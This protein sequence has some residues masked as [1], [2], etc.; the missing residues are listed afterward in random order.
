MSLALPSARFPLPSAKVYRVLCAE[1]GALCG[2]KGV[3]FFLDSRLYRSPRSRP[4]SR[5]YAVS[6]TLVYPSSP[7]PTL[8]VRQVWL[9]IRVC[10][11][12]YFI[13]DVVDDARF[14]AFL[15]QRCTLR[16]FDD[17]AIQCPSPP[18]YPPP[19][20]SLIANLLC[21]DMNAHTQTLSYVLI[22]CY[23][24]SS[25]YPFL[26][27]TYIRM[28]T[29]RLSRYFYYGGTYQKPN[30]LIDN[31]QWQTSWAHIDREIYASRR[32]GETTWC[33]RANCI[34]AS[35]FHLVSI[36]AKLIKWMGNVLQMM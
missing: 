9:S 1:R 24:R 17:G 30:E 21:H 5:G 7:S 31:A 35:F 33:Y 29:V 8:S 3:A 36:S 27:R 11:R 16:K 20:I 26:E 12:L 10:L 18:N 22:E 14:F 2:G 15:S 6:Q 19:R 4:T 23:I 28:K 34:A 25:V 32:D 13:F